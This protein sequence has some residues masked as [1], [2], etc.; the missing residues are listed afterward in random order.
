MALRAVAGVWITVGRN[1]FV[2]RS[3]WAHDQQAR[4]IDLGS[5]TLTRPR[6]VPRWAYGAGT[7]VRDDCHALPQQEVCARL[8][9]RR[10]EI[11]RRF[12][13]AMPSER[14]TLRVEERGINARLDD[15]CGGH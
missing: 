1:A 8:S 6:P 14:D 15:D 9:D 3:R 13:N 7:W 12:F 2:Q 10:D 11:R 5:T 4:R